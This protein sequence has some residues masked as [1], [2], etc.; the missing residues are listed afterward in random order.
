MRFCLAW[1][2]VA[3]HL[4]GIELGK[5]AVYG[6]YL[7]SGFLMTLILNETYLFQFKAFFINRVLR[8]FPIYY[9]VSILT[10]FVFS[11]FSNYV[12]YHLAWSSQIGA[13]E[14][15]ANFLIAPIELLP[16]HE[17]M[18]SAIFRIVP[19]SWS[20]AV[21]LVC[22]FLLWLIVARNKW[23]ACI[24][25]V[26][27]IAY[28]IIV[29]D[30]HWGYRYFPVF[31]AMLPFSIGAAGYFIYKSFPKKYAHETLIISLTLWLIAITSDLAV[32]WYLNL[33]AL[34]LFMIASTHLDV[35]YPNIKRIGKYLGELSYPIFLCHWVVGFV[36]SELLHRKDV[37]YVSIIPILALSY[38][39]SVLANGFIEP[40][41]DKVRANWKT[42]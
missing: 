11:I 20:V 5:L 27:A 39:L 23:S 32:A 18:S 2:V 26:A 40:Y 6:F 8:L 13:K 21:E 37:F 31:A 29:A 38:L 41:R 35:S 34:L 22:Y 12:S 30:L 25:L 24:T 1:F 33:I 17:N 19:T 9:L 4:T 7:I 3:F 16:K 10:I 36:M 14:I 28:Q 15:V 42:A